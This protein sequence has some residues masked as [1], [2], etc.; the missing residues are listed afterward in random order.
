MKTNIILFVGNFLCKH[1][2]NPTFLELLATDLKNKYP[3][4][5]VSDKKNKIFRLLDMLYQF[6]KH[7]DQI[8]LV[9]IDI[10]SSR[11]YYFGLIMAIVSKIHNKPYLLVLSGGNLAERLKH[12]SSFKIIL[13]NSISN[14]SPSKYLLDKFNN[15]NTFYIPNYL[16]LKFYPYKKRE[17]IT[18]NLLWVRSMHTIYNP[19]MAIFV[20]DQ[21]I[22][23][24]PD[25]TLCMVGPAKDNSKTK[26]ISLIKELKLQDHIILKGKL[27]KKEWIELSKEYD[28][29]INTTD[30]DN[31]PVTLLEAMALGLP[32]VSTNVGGIPHLIDDEKT[33]LLVG[34][35]D[36]HSMS[37]RI[38]SLI[39]GELDGLEI[40][41]NARIMMRKY[42]ISNTLPKWIK[43]IDEIIMD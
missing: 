28:I 7:I 41:G 13:N 32:V 8:N 5:I 43:L 42:S 23:S 40:A 6:Y 29:F 36:I 4:H 18:P 11:A 31:H 19:Q 22:K 39:N 21:I 20:L 24:Y 25:A 3:I 15:Y 10:Y 33:G 37:D 27:E 12:S 16:D 26:V 2:M 17:I 14:I 34:P 9:I 38:I 30:F 35:N 1:G